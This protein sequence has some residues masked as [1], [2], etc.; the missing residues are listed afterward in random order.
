[1]ENMNPIDIGTLLALAAFWFSTTK[2]K[3][4]KSEELGRM[5]QQIATLETKSV[6]VDSQLDNINIK[7]NQLMESNA[8]LEAQMR[9]LLGKKNLKLVDTPMS[10][11]SGTYEG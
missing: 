8:R 7:L 4:Q 10:F 9:L 11:A 5:K 2:D 3:A 6:Q 1:M